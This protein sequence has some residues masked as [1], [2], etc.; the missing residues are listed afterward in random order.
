LDTRLALLPLSLYSILIL[1]GCLTTGVSHQQLARH[2]YTHPT[3]LILH[4]LRSSP[5][6]GHHGGP[7]GLPREALATNEDDQLDQQP[8]S[9]GGS[10][11]KCTSSWRSYACCSSGWCSSS[12]LRLISRVYCRPTHPTLLSLLDLIRHQSINGHDF[13]A[14]DQPTTADCRVAGLHREGTRFT[15]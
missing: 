11:S 1:S 6:A 9:A 10:T 8:G 14:W 13:Y 5:P 7:G 3:R 15:I 2:P 4:Q 12:R